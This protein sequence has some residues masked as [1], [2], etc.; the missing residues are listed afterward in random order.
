[1]RYRF[2]TIV[3][4][5]TTLFFLL[6]ALSSG[7]APGRFAGRIGFTIANSGGYNEIMAQYTGFFLTAALACATSL[8]G[9]IS[10]RAAL[11]LV[12]VVF[13]G[14]LGGRLVSLAL[15]GGFAGYGPDIRA[16]YL[17]DAMGLT[18]ALAALALDRQ[19]KV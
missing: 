5:V 11:I 18:L 16:L 8:F 4:V 14:L 3:L 15:N 7:L 13:G 12:T 19:V 17:I 6:T 9:V 2:G 10:R 1:M